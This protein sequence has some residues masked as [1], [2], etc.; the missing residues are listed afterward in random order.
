VTKILDVLLFAGPALAL[1]FG[2]LF[3]FSSSNRLFARRPRQIALG[4]A[5][6]MIVSLAG[7]LRMR[8]VESDSTVLL[9]V[10]GLA[11]GACVIGFAGAFGFGLLIRACFGGFSRLGARQ[12]FGDTGVS[13][14]IA[15]RSRR[16]ALPPG[17]RIKQGK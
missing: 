2:F 8:Q 14:L 6:S 13:T 15:R 17:P 11:L 3:A 5:I 7:A 12:H 16:S 4:V 9:T 10:I 1:L